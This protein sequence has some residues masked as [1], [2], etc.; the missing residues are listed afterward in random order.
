MSAGKKRTS[1]LIMNND[2]NFWSMY[3][4]NLGIVK[5][6]PKEKTNS[7]LGSF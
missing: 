3:E 4:K 7:K 5:E 6:E 1:P 2:D